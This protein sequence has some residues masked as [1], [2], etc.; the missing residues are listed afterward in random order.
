VQ[1]KLNGVNLG[2]EDTSAPYG[3]TWNTT[4]MANGSHTL[5][6]EARDAAGNRTTA[7][8]SVLVSNILNTAPTISS[9]ANLSINAGSSTGPRS[10][11]V[12]D[13]E[14]GAGSLTV[15]GSS[16]NPTLVPNNS[17]VFGG[18]GSSR[19]VTATPAANQTGTATITVTVTDGTLSKSTSFVL[20]VSAPT[21]GLTFSATSGAI[22]APFV[23]SNGTISQAA[24][25]GVTAGGRAVY[26]FNIASAGNYTVSAQVNAPSDGANSFFVN[27]DS[28]PTD[29]LMIWD[30]PITSGLTS[31][32]VSWRG[33]GTYDNNQ[34]APKVFALAAGT[35]QLIVRGREANCQLGTITIAPAP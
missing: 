9:I 35:H 13:T 23:V 19:T 4:T 17:I 18:S 5:S 29:P 30:V 20:T 26:T 22:A 31:R 28:E 12:G 3:L 14:T 11:T 7:T 24:L 21:S 8:R 27:I 6:A 16:S 25:S 15:S 2:S 32:T 34:F 1:F 33:N 10:F